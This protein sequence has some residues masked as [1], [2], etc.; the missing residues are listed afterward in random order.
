MEGPDADEI[1]DTMPANCDPFE[2]MLVDENDPVDGDDTI[3]ADAEVAGMIVGLLG[4]MAGEER[5]EGMTDPW[6]LLFASCSVEALL[7]FEFVFDSGTVVPLLIAEFDPL[8]TG[9]TVLFRSTLVDIEPK[10]NSF[11]D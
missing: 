8:V 9:L 1:P 7:E 3:A 2:L 6:L 11:D 10:E 5:F 4:K